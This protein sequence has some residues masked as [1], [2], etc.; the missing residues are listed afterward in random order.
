LYHQ[1]PKQNLGNPKTHTHNP[2]ME[3]LEVTMVETIG[4]NQ[5]FSYWQCIAKMLD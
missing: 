1:I 3:G 4:G 2:M 5:H